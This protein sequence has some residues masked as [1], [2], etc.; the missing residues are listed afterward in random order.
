ML[1]AKG[2]CASGLL[3]GSKV[4]SEEGML[5][6]TD[7][8]LRVDQC[9][10]IA[11]RD[12]GKRFHVYKLREYED[13]MKPGDDIMLGTCVFMEWGDRSHYIVGRVVRINLNGV[14]VNST[15]LIKTM[16]TLLFKVEILE[17]IL[18]V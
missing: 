14:K 7:S 13:R 4:M 10:D 5:E 8:N 2:E 16:R 11:S 9:A 6:S 3:N 17:V 12:R 18:L 1:T 15:K